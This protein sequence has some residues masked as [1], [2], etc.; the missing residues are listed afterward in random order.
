MIG[1][2]LFFIATTL[3]MIVAAVSPSQASLVGKSVGCSILSGSYQ[4]SASSA[5]I[6]GGV[7]FYIQDLSATNLIGVNISETTFT[8]FNPFAASVTFLND[9]EFLFDIFSAAIDLNASYPR[10][11]N[12]SGVGGGVNASTVPGTNNLNLRI[13]GS[14]TFNP[15]G[16]FD[17]SYASLI[18]STVV[19]VPAALPLLLSGLAGLG[20]LGFM[21]RRK[22]LDAENASMSA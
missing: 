16:H 21:R 13:V 6:G 18:D 7:E 14:L 4:C 9:E 1:K 17:A 19:P 3:S 8:F 22:P 12:A 15:G 10:V 5:V 2:T 20:A 11:Q